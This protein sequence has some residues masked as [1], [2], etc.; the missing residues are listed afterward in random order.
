VPI[1]EATSFGVIQSIVNSASLGL[2]KNLRIRNPCSNDPARAS[3]IYGELSFDTELL[4][5][6]L[7]E[8]SRR[9]TEHDF[10]RTII[11]NCFLAIACS[12]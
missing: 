5:Q 3:F 10:G 12:L 9:S 8:D 11:P 7:L 2:K 1:A 6:T 4:A